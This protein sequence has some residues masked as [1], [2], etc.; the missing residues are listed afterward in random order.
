M[1]LSTSK[2]VFV[3]ALAL[4]SAQIAWSQH[5]LQSNLPVDWSAIDPERGGF[6]KAFCEGFDLY[7]QHYE[8]AQ[9]GWAYT[10]DQAMD[11]WVEERPVDSGVQVAISIADIDTVRA[12]GVNLEYD[13]SIDDFVGPCVED[14]VNPTG[15]LAYLGGPSLTFITGG[16]VTVKDLG[17]PWNDFGAAGVANVMQYDFGLS[18]HP[19]GA[20]AQLT[21]IVVLRFTQGPL[22]NGNY[23]AWL[24][25]SEDDPVSNDNQARQT[26]YNNS[27][28]SGSILPHDM[29]FCLGSLG[30]FK[31]GFEDGNTSAWTN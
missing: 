21:D 12:W 3:S 14:E 2:A 18:P 28:P 4:F 17:V 26:N 22:P 31:D 13:P 29:V 6:F 9:T 16:E 10:S 19:D 24:W 11:F 8:P 23:C 7:E 30:I 27:P 25:L 15:F 20:L 5:G 1:V